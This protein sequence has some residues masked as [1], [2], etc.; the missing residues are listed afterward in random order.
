MDSITFEKLNKRYG[1]LQV[2]QEVSANVPAGQVVGLLGRNGAGKTTLFRILYGLISADSGKKSILGMDPEVALV[3]M[4]QRV[5][6]VSE[7]CHLYPW[8]TARNL[9]KFCAPLYPKWDPSLFSKLLSDLDIPEDRKVDALSKGTR[10]KLM[11]ALALATQPEV[12]LLDE[13]FGGMDAVVREQ[14]VS[15]LIRSL[16]EKGVTIFLST[17]EIEEFSGVCDRIIIL[18]KGS[19]L[20]DRETEALT[21]SVRRVVA[22]L[23]NPVEALP[24]HPSI[25]TSRAHGTQAEFVMK[26][27]TPE[28]AAAVLANF[29]VRETRFEGLTLPEIFVAFTAGKEEDR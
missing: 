27:F 12:L 9:E 3:Q 23:E 8:M 11:L 4:R 2:L 14:I 22:T 15:T 5:A 7:E 13:P 6:F 18:S 20:V 29:K 21:Q 16:A 17:H 25:L 24:S 28:A 10:R 26:D 19:F 1:S